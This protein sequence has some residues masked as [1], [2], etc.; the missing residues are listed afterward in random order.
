MALTGAANIFA[1][2][3]NVLKKN[4]V[5]KIY[6]NKIYDLLETSTVGIQVQFEEYH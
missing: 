2:D 3:V 4:S 5:L 6:N 1:I